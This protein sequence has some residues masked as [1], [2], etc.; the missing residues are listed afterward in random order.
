[1]VGDDYENVRNVGG[2]KV[3]ARRK[4]VVEE[5]AHNDCPP[6]MNNSLIH[7]FDVSTLNLEANAYYE[8]ANFDSYE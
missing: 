8:L 6:A 5:N 4:Q 7:L 1:M 2:V 3:L